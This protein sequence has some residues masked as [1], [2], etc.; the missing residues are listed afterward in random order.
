MFTLINVGVNASE[1]F[2]CDL[3]SVRLVG[4]LHIKV[5]ISIILEVR[6]FISSVASLDV[7][8]YN[9]LGIKGTGIGLVEADSIDPSKTLQRIIS[10]LNLNSGIIWSTC[11]PRFI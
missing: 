2:Y 6:P 1:L 11:K 8:P 4:K 7:L 10:I 5:I 3:L 9:M